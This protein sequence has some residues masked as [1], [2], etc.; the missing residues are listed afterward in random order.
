MKR[1][2]TSLA[3]FFSI[4]ALSYALF[5][6]F[7]LPKLLEATNGPNIKDQ[8]TTSFANA[9]KSNCQ[10]LILGNSRHYC[11]INPDKFSI[12]S[13]NFSHNNDSYNQLYWKLHWLLENGVKPEF[14]ILSVD[15]FQFSIFS[16]T[17]NYAYGP[18]LGAGYLSDYPKRNYVFEYYKSLLKPEKV[19]KL[20]KGP[21][22]MQA[23]KPNG[24]Y[25]RNGVPSDSDFIKRDPNR[26]EIQVRY[27]EKTLELC[28]QRNIKVFMVM[29]PLRD[30]EIKQYEKGR[31]PEFE[32]FIEKYVGPNVYYLDYSKDPSFKMAD[33]IDFSHLNQKAADRFSLKLNDT[34]M[35]IAGRHSVVSNTQQ[36]TLQ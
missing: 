18:L 29:A 9:K 14:V 21:N 34:L 25:V 24:Q 6:F 27:F 32:R 7:I 36:S 8:L 22:Y 26:K 5:S 1:F 11:G 23:L 12:K 17:R 28:K 3:V 13:Y 35:K 16:G 31:I 19:R 30:I 20:V 2:L 15:Y 10:L 4:A 33:F